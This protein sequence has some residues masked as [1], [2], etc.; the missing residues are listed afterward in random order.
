MLDIV[1][2]SN[3]ETG[4]RKLGKLG[5]GSLL[6][7]YL[8]FLKGSSSSVSKPSESHYEAEPSNHIASFYILQSEITI[9]SSCRF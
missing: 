3:L 2:K 5:K 6:G 8:L 7:P 1:S 4:K 9:Q